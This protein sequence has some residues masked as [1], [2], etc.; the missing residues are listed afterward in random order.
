MSRYDCEAHEI[1]RAAVGVVRAAKRP[2][3]RVSERTS[4]PSARE[5]GSR[6]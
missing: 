2:V 1:R 5:S 4:P 3:K 6:P